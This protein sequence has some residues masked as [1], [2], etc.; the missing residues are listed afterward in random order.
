AAKLGIPTAEAS[1]EGIKLMTRADNVAAFT[2][3]DNPTS[4]HYTAKL[5]SDFFV[6][7][8][9]LSRPVNLEVLLNDRFVRAADP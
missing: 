5:Y 2:P 9:S 8:G 4:I 6:R 7:T 1:L 3:G